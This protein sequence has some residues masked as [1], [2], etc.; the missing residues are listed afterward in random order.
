MFNPIL[1]FESGKSRGGAANVFIGGVSGTINTPAL[2][3][4]KFLN[5]PSG[6][7]FSASN[8]QNFTINGSDIECYIGVDYQIKFAAFRNNLSV[9]YYEDY[10]SCK[11]INFAAFFGDT[12][13]VMNLKNVFFEN[14]L[15]LGSNAF[16]QDGSNGLLETAIFPNCTSMEGVRTFWHIAN[17]RVCYMPKCVSIGSSVA[18]NQVFASC[19]NKLKVYAEPTM[20]TINAGGVE[21]DLAYVTDTLLGQVAYVTNF[22]APDPVTTLAAATVYATGVK[23]T[24]T[25]PAS[26][27]RI[28]YYELYINGVFSKNI[29]GNELFLWNLTNGATYTFEL[30]AVDNF[31]NK[32]TISNMIT[33]VINGSDVINGS[34]L[35]SDLIAYY[36]LNNNTYDFFENYN[37]TGTAIT[38]AAGKVGDAAVFNGKRSFI[39]IADNDAFSFTDGTNDKPFSIA[40]QVKFTSLGGANGSWLIDKRQFGTAGNQEW[41]LIYFQGKLSLSLLNYNT[42]DY[43][44]GYQTISP[45]LNVWHSIIATY[46][47]S[48]LHT[49]IKVYFNKSAAASTS[50][51]SGTYT[52]MINSTSILTLGKRGFTAA[53]YLSGSEDEVII[54][55]KALNQT[56]VDYIYDTNNAGNPII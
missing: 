43:I 30:I 49:G 25:T 33:Q 32:S 44:Q 16:N 2:L 34:L 1:F 12:G 11:R 5:Y 37:G 15:S 50:L 6:T 4:A 28:D 7:A 8:I 19:S 26:I 48:G 13:F 14:V 29:T 45:T 53:G 3:A 38:Y 39:T 27:N 40:M 36:K 41:Q 55:N 56:E 52:K 20:A 9:T 21:G 51:M 42:V 23:L 35:I 22:T 47:G 18:D 10:L 24:W 46:D 17:L 31:Y 54:F